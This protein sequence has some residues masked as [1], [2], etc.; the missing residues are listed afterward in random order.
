MAVVRRQDDTLGVIGEL[1]RRSEGCRQ[2]SGQMEAT[3]AGLP[4]L[5]EQLQ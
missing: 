2:A 3:S 4:E 1:L 5:I